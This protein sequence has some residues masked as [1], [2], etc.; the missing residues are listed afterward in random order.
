M[1]APL[2]PAT[3]AVRGALL[4]LA[5]AAAT[6]GVLSLAGGPILKLADATGSGRVATLPFADL[7]GGLC[8]LA[9][10]GCWLWWSAGAVTLVA[11]LVRAGSRR[12][13]WGPD[14]AAAGS[15]LAPRMV[16]ATVLVAL[17]VPLLATALPAEAAAP[18]APAAR[19][20]GDPSRL[21]AAPSAAARAL[22]GLGLPDRV[23]GPA[24]RPRQVVVR[25]GDS[26]WSL[27][28]RLVAPAGADDATV[29]EAVRS[30]R[31][32]NHRVL[33]PDPDLIFPGTRLALPAARPGKERP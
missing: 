19:A 4:L 1:T 31:R 7:L 16:R 10:A 33:G 2:R 32:L 6:L 26:L 5:G 9:L 18:A 3:L 22:A 15:R 11:C 12:P 21:P 17:G 13:G 14:P 29:A 28:E 27:S 30:L 25:P 23:A 24:A 8:A 20:G